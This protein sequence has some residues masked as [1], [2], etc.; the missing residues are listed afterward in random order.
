MQNSFS[1]V[2]VFSLEANKMND[3]H[4]NNSLKFIIVSAFFPQPRVF[5]MC[6]MSAGI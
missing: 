6:W 1:Y 5:I 3:A 4:R 2:Y